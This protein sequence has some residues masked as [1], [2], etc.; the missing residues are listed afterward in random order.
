MSKNKGGINLNKTSP[1]GRN[2]L[3]TLKDGIGGN[4]AAEKKVNLSDSNK[5]NKTI[6]A[7][8]PEGTASN[9]NQLPNK[10]KRSSGADKLNPPQEPSMKNNKKKG[11][12]APLSDE[13]PSRKKKKHT[14]KPEQAT[15]VKPALTVSKAY[16]KKKEL[17]T[18]GDTCGKKIAKK[19]LSGDDYHE[20]TKLHHLTNAG[21]LK[22]K[23]ITGTKNE[24]TQPKKH[25]ESYRISDDQY[26]KETL[27][28]PKGSSTSLVGDY[29]SV[30]FTKFPE[31][32][33]H[34]VSNDGVGEKQGVAKK[35]I[36]HRV[37]AR[38]IKGVNESQDNGS[39]ASNTNLTLQGANNLKDEGAL[40][41]ASSP[42]DSINIFRDLRIGFKIEEATMRSYI[43]MGRYGAG[44]TI[45]DKLFT[46]AETEESTL[47][48]DSS[49]NKQ[50]ILSEYVSILYSNQHS[51]YLKVA[52][53]I[54]LL[55]LFFCYRG[56]RHFKC[57]PVRGQRT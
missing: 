6:I 39:S 37:R 15:L 23:E 2:N 5:N 16:D 51:Y 7:T 3:F 4:I 9:K 11:S 31:G 36:K 25:K 33:P 49:P 34:F 24:K 53:N 40:N 28:Y 12:A 26:L 21:V 14:S 45:A 17:V 52:T 42:D 27:K 44:T 47:Y 1:E 13:R 8:T 20:V 55:D 30:K 18:L 56:W 32:N 48:L 46:R 43:S 54:A 29:E 10:K 57:L 19:Q 22:K 35:T 38:D 50:Y 41:S